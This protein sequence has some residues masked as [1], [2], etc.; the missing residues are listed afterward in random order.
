MLNIKGF[1]KL[2][3]KSILLRKYEAQLPKNI[4]NSWLIFIVK[5]YDIYSLL[6][7]RKIRNNYAITGEI[8]LNGYITAIGGLD[9]KI[10]GGIRAGVKNFIYPKDNSREF[11]IC[12]DKY[13]EKLLDCNFY[14]VSN[15]HEVI[16]YMLI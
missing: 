16:K 13:C 14:E 12:Y 11:K 8:F 5:L 6:L 10:L 1:I 9:L 15:I 4:N 2:F 7:N 3:K